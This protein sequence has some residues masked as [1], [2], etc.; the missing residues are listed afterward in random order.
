M[1][2]DF[3]IQK[4][5]PIIATATLAMSQLMNVEA[6][7]EPGAV[8]LLLISLAGFYLKRPARRRL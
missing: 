1:N 2:F 5:N 4:S 6:V 8:M 3:S 7:P